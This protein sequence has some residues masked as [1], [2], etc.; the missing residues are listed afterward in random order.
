[1]L[2]LKE[3]KH[4]LGEREEEGIWRHFCLL[5]ASLLLLKSDCR[6]LH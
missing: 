6:I 4:N 2:V 3:T 1:M 5:K